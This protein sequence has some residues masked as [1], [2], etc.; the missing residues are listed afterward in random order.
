MCLMQE[1][2]KDVK[3]P[4]AILACKHFRERNHVFNK[5]PKFIIK[6]KFTNTTKSKDILR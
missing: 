6:D 2:R 5:H 1:D 4:D 3:Q